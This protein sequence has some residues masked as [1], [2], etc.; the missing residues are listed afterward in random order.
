MAPA[1]TS[2]MSRTNVARSRPSE[3]HARTAIVS[4]EH[5]VGA[6]HDEEEDEEDDE[7]GDEDDEEEGV[8]GTAEHERRPTTRKA[9]GPA[10]TS[11]KRVCAASLKRPHASHAGRHPRR[12][13]R[14]RLVCWGAILPLV[15][16]TLL[17]MQ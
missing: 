3:R 6:K 11:R 7:E 14:P 13:L 17:S 1:H 5:I 16:M 2:S 8:G 9:R 10:Q 12:R 15:P 4:R